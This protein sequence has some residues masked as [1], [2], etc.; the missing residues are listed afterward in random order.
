[1][2]SPLCVLAAC[3][4]AAS[5]LACDRSAAEPDCGVLRVMPLGDSITEAEDGHASYRYWL[6]NALEREGRRVDFVGSQT[7]VYRGTPQYSDFDS[8]HEGH[9]GWTTLQVR[10]RIDRWAGQSTPDVVLLMLGTND[11]A[12]NI[13]GTVDNLSAIIGSLRAHRPG[14]SVLIAQVPP[15]GDRETGAVLR[16][17]GV[18]NRVQ[19]RIARQL[20]R[21]DARVVVV[22][23]WTGFDV[24]ADTYDGVHPSESGERKLAE[25]WLEA[26]NALAP[27]PGATCGAAP[28]G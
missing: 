16:D 20:D 11:G 1:M 2:R 10:E 14:V 3:W 24:R 18:L 17:I 21:P 19:A 7:G 26:L 22:D 23:Q 12:R 28:S 4:C 15:V 6:F 25:R 8:D 5:I 27:W 13:P 9:W